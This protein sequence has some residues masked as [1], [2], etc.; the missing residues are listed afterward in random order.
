MREQNEPTKLSITGKTLA[1]LAGQVFTDGPYEYRIYVKTG[2]LGDS[3]IVSIS[4]FIENTPP[5]VGVDLYLMA[6]K[7]VAEVA[8]DHIENSEWMINKVIIEQYEAL[9]EM[10]PMVTGQRSNIFG[11]QSYRNLEEK[12]RTNLTKS[13]NFQQV[14]DIIDVRKRKL[15]KVLNYMQKTLPTYKQPLNIT[16]TI[17][18]EVKRHNEEILAPSIKADINVTMVEKP[19]ASDHTAR[20]IID[21]IKDSIYEMIEDLSPIDIHSYDNITI[22]VS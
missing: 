13:I 20:V 17:S 22:K 4:I 7:R 5:H 11:L 19:K 3:S 21:A 12:I 16:Y 15:T 6:L 2:E 14:N 10:T 9:G 8:G 1:G 18:G